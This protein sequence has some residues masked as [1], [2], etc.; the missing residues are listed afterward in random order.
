MSA[1]EPPKI[2]RAGEWLDIRKRKAGMWAYLLNRVTGIALVIYLYLHLTVLSTLARGPSA[3][4]DFVS[5]AGSPFFLSLD[6]IL[7]AGI[8]IHGLNGIRLM[9]MSLGVGVK[10]EKVLFGGL[11]AVAV[12]VLVAAGIRMYGG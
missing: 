8:L 11:V 4:N 10:A 3:W 7:L 1:L 5:L 6:V 12:V 2:R 9:L